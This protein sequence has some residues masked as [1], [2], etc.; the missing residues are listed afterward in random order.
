MKKMYLARTNWLIAFIAILSLC[1]SSAWAQFTATVSPT[2]GV[3]LQ[4]T[5]AYSFTITGTSNSTKFGSARI[6]IPA[7]FTNLL[8]TSVT[9]SKS[10]WSAIVNN[11]NIDISTSGNNSAYIGSSEYVIVNVTADNPTNAVISTWTTTPYQNNTFGGGAL[12]ITG[13]QPIVTI[14]KADQTITFNALSNKNYGDAPFGIS[15]TSSSGLPI[16]FNVVNS[17]PVTITGNTVTIT[18]VGSVTVRASQSG[19]A[20]YNSALSIDRVFTVAAKSITG[21]FTADN[22]VYDGNTSATVLTRNLSGV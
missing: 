4:P 14:S 16:T 1:S 12:T 20:T 15:A 11:G 18:G 17:S 21:S 10:N 8:I 6:S 9:S 19:N 22:K 13:S 3:V 5:K 2:T 7:G